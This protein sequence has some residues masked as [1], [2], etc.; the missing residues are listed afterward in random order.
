VSELPHLRVVV[1]R[2]AE[3]VA[4]AVALIAGAREGYAPARVARMAEA[5]GA[6]ATAAGLDEAAASRCVVAAWLHD[7]GMIALPD[8]ALA[9]SDPAGYVDSPLIRAHVELGAA[10]VTRVPELA[11]AAGAIRHHHERYDGGGY[12]DGLAGEAIP[13]TARVVAAADALATAA[14]QAAIAPRERKAAAQRLRALAGT[15][16][17]PQLADAAIAVLAAEADAAGE[18]LPRTA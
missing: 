2:R 8:A 12:P 9:P 14:P 5:A 4:R 18:Y 16:L 13:I 15:A 7:I 6:I 3:D 17:D 10:L 1:D 11:P